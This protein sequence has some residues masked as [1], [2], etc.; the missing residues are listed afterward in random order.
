MYKLFYQRL[1]FLF[2]ITCIMLSCNEKV[3]IETPEDPEAPVITSFTP[4]RGTPGTIIEI[5]GQYLGLVDS[6]MIGNSSINILKERVTNEYIVAEVKSGL[7]SGRIKAINRKGAGYSSKN[8]TITEP[9]DPQI[10][11]IPSGAVVNDYIVV[12]GSNLNRVNRVFFRYTVNNNDIDVYTSFAYQTRDSIGVV[13]PS[14]RSTTAKFGYTYGLQE[15]ENIAVEDGTTI[16]FSSPQLT[17]NPI[18]ENVYSQKRFVINGD[19]LNVVD[20]IMLG[21]N[22][23]RFYKEQS[24][25]YKILLKTASNVSAGDYNLDFFDISGNKI[26]TESISISPNESPV[27][28]TLLNYVNKDEQAFT[29]SISATN[30]NKQY[31]V[32]NLPLVNKIVDVSP[33]AV[34]PPEAGMLFG[35]LEL[36]YD[37]KKLV[38]MGTT[39]LTTLAFAHAAPVTAAN[40]TDLQKYSEPV[41][42]FWI[43][44][45]GTTPTFDLYASLASGYYFSNGYR[46][47]VSNSNITTPLHT[48]EKEWKL[49]AIRLADATYKTGS[50]SYQAITSEEVQYAFFQKKIEEIRIRIRTTKR[51][52][53]EDPAETIEVNMANFFVSDRVIEGAIDITQ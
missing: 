21:N 49:V 26:H 50:S 46:A 18:T 48:A 22:K 1:A 45:N 11:T 53:D 10:T 13:V 29:K 15:P 16:T 38:E 31:L 6:V 43:S 32:Y 52:T 28:T 25:R 51:P 9:V 30:A 14:I 36:K 27:N 41:I 42:H 2:L 40:A 5:R 44:T 35:H 4:E 24:N 19:N 8:F 39:N 17:I 7:S 23:M 12:K 37:A 34:N 3:N 47:T 33:T 20:S